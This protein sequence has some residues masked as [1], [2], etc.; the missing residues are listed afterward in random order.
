MLLLR[1]QDTGAQEV[2]VYWGDICGSGNW[3]L[4]ECTVD[5]HA[6]AL[7]FSY[8]GTSYFLTHSINTVFTIIFWGLGKNTWEMRQ[9][10]LCCC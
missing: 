2:G 3:D 10:C 4:D 9:K 6:D 8:K 5:V 7:F 1:G